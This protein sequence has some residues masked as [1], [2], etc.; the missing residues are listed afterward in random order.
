MDLPVV[1][2]LEEALKGAMPFHWSDDYPARIGVMPR[3]GGDAD[4][5]W[6]DINPCYIFHTLK[7]KDEQDGVGMGLALAKRI[8]EAHGG[9]IS[10]E[11][12]AGQGTTIHFTLPKDIQLLERKV[13][14]VGEDHRYS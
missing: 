4:V 9:T 5:K 7:T 3:T 13:F 12:E 11:T 14:L 10:A 1:F 6:F 8:I 2:S